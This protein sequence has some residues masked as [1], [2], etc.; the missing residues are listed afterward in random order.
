MGYN[1]PMNTPDARHA[2][3][4]IVVLTLALSGLAGC[5]SGPES[6][7]STVQ[8]PLEHVKNSIEAGEE[9]KQTVKDAGQ[10]RARQADELINDR[11]KAR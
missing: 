3:P 6:V 11:L 1:Q 10:P 7:T 4:K 8:A 2:L 9:L 5:G